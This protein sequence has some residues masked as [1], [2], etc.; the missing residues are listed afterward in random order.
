MGHRGVRLCHDPRVVPG[1]PVG[2]YL[3]HDGPV[4]EQSE[5]SV[6]GT[7]VL[8]TETR[9]EKKSGSHWCKDFNTITGQSIRLLEKDER[10]RCPRE[11]ESSSR[12]VSRLRLTLRLHVC[13]LESVPTVYRR[14][15]NSRYSPSFLLLPSPSFSHSDHT[16]RGSR[17][18]HE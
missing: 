16:R 10:E 18:R 1:V 14:R 7:R 15:V 11:T 17:P 13:V 3:K 2:T 8:L 6:L 4:L 9:S 12:P 5:S